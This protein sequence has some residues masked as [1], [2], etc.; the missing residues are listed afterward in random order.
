VSNKYRIRVALESGAKA[1][2]AKLPP[3][4]R[5]FVKALVKTV[6]RESIGRITPSGRRLSGELA[7]TW[8]A[9]GE[10]ELVI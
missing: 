5:A 1:A 10:L 2:F 9:S 8:R 3:T 4:V 7:F 6:A